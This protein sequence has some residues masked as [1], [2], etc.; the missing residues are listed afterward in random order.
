MFRIHWISEPNVH[1]TCFDFWEM[2][3]RFSA[4]IFPAPGICLSMI[5][6][7]IKDDFMF[8]SRWVF[9]FKST[10]TGIVWLYSDLGKHKN[11][12]VNLIKLSR[13]SRDSFLF[14]LKKGEWIKSRNYLISEIYRTFSQ[15]SS[16]EV[17][18]FFGL[19]LIKTEFHETVYPLFCH[20]ALVKL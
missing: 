6:F 2:A 19:R 20:P 14:C 9:A 11:R 8:T 10:E 12:C 13:F 4:V 17:S 1:N 5:N 18:P 7:G 16:S 3:F 15:A